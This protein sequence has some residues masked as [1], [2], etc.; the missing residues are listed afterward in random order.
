VVVAFT[1]GVSADRMDERCPGV[2]RRL[3][4]RSPVVCST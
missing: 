1:A 2:R 4:R 3:H